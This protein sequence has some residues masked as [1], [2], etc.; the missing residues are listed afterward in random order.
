MLSGWYSACGSERMIAFSSTAASGRPEMPASTFCRRAGFRSPPIS[1]RTPRIDRNRFS[2]SMRSSSGL[3]WMRNSAGSLCF[4]R[5]PAACTFAA[6]MHSSISRCASF[7][8][9]A[10]ISVGL[11]AASTSTLTS[12]A[13]KS[14]AP[15]F[16]R[17]LRRARYTWCR[18]S[19]TGA[20][21]ACGPRASGSRP[22]RWAATRVYVKRACER[23]TAA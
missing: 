18:Q 19:I 8:G 22:S 21:R 16:S 7:L 5:K 23:I 9:Y 13:S 1:S 4:L 15:R 10:R 3:P 20:R 17:S 12:G 6:I 14:S 11:P 2:S